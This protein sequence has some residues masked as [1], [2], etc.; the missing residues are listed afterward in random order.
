MATRPPVPERRGPSRSRAALAVLGAAAL[1][2]TTGTSRE[3]L[4]PD[5][6]GTGVA[7]MR[8]LVGSIGLIGFVVWRGRGSVLLQLWRRP[9]VWVIGAGVAGYQAFFFI[10][11]QRTGVAVAALIA[12]GSAPFLAGL[13]GWA[14][15]EGAPGWLWVLSTAIAV[16][17][18]ALLVSGS[19]AEGDGVGMLSALVAGGCYAVFTVLGV[20]LAREGF[21]GGDTLAASFS[22]G[23][24]VLL[25]A[26]F[27]SSWWLTP[28]GI[29]L[30]LWLG[31][32]TTTVAYLLFGLGL[33][34]LQPGHIATLTLF[35]PA[36]ATVL[37]VVVLH[38][39]I[40]L[41]GWM[42]CGLVVGA[43]ALLGIVEARGDRAADGDG[44]M[45]LMEKTV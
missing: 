23:A 35:E 31:I 44:G 26:V 1:F 14:L 17:G 41:V 42:G 40:G 24:V 20:R 43:L 45:Q 4:V 5:A 19:L 33:T 37:G 22:L 34:V 3:L 15:R 21:H 39:P 18:L 7:A 12:L 36:V 6:P 30:T 11:T 9:I 8:L 10:G 16:F 38:E 32:A 27:A 13:L 25:P 29:A 2:G 28:S